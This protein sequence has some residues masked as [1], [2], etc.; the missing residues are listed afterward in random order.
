MMDEQPRAPADV[1]KALGFDTPLVRHVL[2]THSRPGPNQRYHSVDHNSAHNAARYVLG[3]GENVDRRRALDPDS[4]TDEAALN[5]RHRNES[6]D[7]P[8]VDVLLL[9]SIN[10]MVRMGVCA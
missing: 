3:P 6:R 2:W 1:A 8:A 5:K 7:W 9:N 10:A 4:D